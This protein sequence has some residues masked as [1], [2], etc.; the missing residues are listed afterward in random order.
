MA[1]KSES[2][3]KALEIFKYSG[4]DFDFK[5]P[6]RNE[7][8]SSKVHKEIDNAWKGSSFLDNKGWVW[9]REDRLHSILRTTKGNAAYL[10]DKIYDKYKMNIGNTTYVR[11]FEIVKLIYKRIEESGAGKTEKYLALSQKYY[12]AIT[13][14]DKAR[15]LRLE[16]G[17]DMVEIRKAL[18]KKRKN[19]YKIDADELTLEPL[20]FK[21]AEFSHIRSVSL[22]PESA[23]NFEN[24]LLVNKE[25]HKLITEKSINDE[26]ELFELCEKMKWSVAWYDPYKEQFN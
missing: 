1:N 8:L 13:N 20:K 5:E 17:R 7:E 2:D 19:K 3:C 16:Y 25:T 15:I 10:L 26:D 22:Y 6:E 14:S 4:N 24:G 21:T 18:K 9:I 23:G 12:D 11:G